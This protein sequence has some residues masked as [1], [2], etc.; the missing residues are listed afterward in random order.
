LMKAVRAMRQR[1]HAA[2]ASR[3]AALAASGRETGE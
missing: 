2:M 1:R 3:R